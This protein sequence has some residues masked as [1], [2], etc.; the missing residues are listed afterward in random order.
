VSQAIDA[1]PAVLK[2]P[3]A[4][5]KDPHEVARRMALAKNAKA[6]EDAKQ[7]EIAAYRAKLAEGRAALEWALTPEKRFLDE[8]KKGRCGL[9]ETLLNERDPEAAAEA[10]LQHKPRPPQIDIN[11]TGLCGNTGLHHAAERYHTEVVTL[12]LSRGAAV[13][14]KNELGKT[15]LHKVCQRVGACGLASGAAV[16][17]ACCRCH[18]L[19]VRAC[20][21]CACVHACVVRMPADYSDRARFRCCFRCF[22]SRLLSQAC[23][24]GNIAVIRELIDAGSADINCVDNDGFTPLLKAAQY[25]H[26]VV[27]GLLLNYN[28]LDLDKVVKPSYED[29]VPDAL[30]HNALWYALQVSA[31]V[32]SR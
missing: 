4:R 31:S 5:A 6:K 17:V 13:N 12:L 21:R 23:H 22:F 25:G 8:C 11:L 28:K 19:A 32:G 10:E 27:V 1:P 9:I 14:C 20:C 2:G 18:P 7:A 15:P 26:A 24:F 3:I 30:R 16:A 29:G